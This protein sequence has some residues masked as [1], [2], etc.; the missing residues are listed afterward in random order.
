VE[1]RAAPLR[2]GVSWH[3]PADYSSRKPT[4]LQ[5]DLAANWRTQ[6]SATSAL[7][8]ELGILRN[9]PIS[10]TPSSSNATHCNF[11]TNV[12]SCE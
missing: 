1:L 3:G 8:F 6:P 5:R 4:N 7:R 11:F 10:N 9:P 12:F 2:D